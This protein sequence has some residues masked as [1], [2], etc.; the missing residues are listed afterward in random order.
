MHEILEIIAKQIGVHLGLPVP[1]V[2]PQRRGRRLIPQLCKT[3]GYTVGAE[4]GVRTGSY[5][6]LFCQAGLKMYCVDPWE[7]YL[8][9]SSSKQQRHYEEARDRLKDYDATLIKKTSMDAVHDF[10]DGS[11]DMIY[12]DGRHEFDYVC[13]DLIEWCPKVRSGGMIALHDYNLTA[14]KYAVDA[15]TAAHQVNPWFVLKA[16]N[17][18]ALWVK[19]EPKRIGRAILT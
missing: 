9:Y 5:S 6:E 17:P 8:R 18:S 14:V 13:R 15:Y 12:I 19:P 10:Q 7:P 1:I 4:I 16:S 3:L 2:T 11:L